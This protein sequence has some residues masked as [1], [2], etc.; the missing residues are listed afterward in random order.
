MEIQKQLAD[1]I[2]PVGVLLERHKDNLLIDDN[3]KDE[4]RQRLFFDNGGK[5]LFVAHMDTILPPKIMGYSKDTIWATGLDDRLGCLL[6]YNLGHEYGADILLTDLEESF[7]T[8]AADHICKD[9]NWIVEF[10]RRGNDVVTYNN[11][12][13]EFL[14]ALKEHWKIGIGVYSDI[15]DLK[16]P[17]CSF[18]LGIGYEF[19]HNEDSF[20]D[21]ITLKQQLTAF[22]L[23]YKDN[24]D[25]T[26]QIENYD[27]SSRGRGHRYHKWDDTEYW[28]L[29]D[30]TDAEFTSKNDDEDDED[31]YGECSLCGW[32]DIVKIVFNVSICQSCFDTVVEVVRQRILS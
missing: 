7:A 4:I 6:A 19:A 32:S 23:F 25:K 21:L 12:S 27:P 20:V 8:T 5:V 9:Y 24:I 1:W 31:D 30:K 14:V 16:T 15:C 29:K 10:D 18:N 13:P 26:Y 28:D 3:D 22:K 11:D 17:T 2:V